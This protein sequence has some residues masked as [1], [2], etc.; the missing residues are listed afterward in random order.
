MNLDTNIMNTKSN[1]MN[2]ASSLSLK[3][4]KDGRPVALHSEIDR[5]LSLSVIFSC[6]L[7]FIRMIHTGRNTFLFL[8]WNLFLAW[9]PYLI[10][11]RLTRMQPFRPRILFAGLMLAWILLSRTL[12]ISSP[13][14]SMWAIIIM[15]A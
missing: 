13:I 2:L 3:P 9:L 6:L 1:S 15:T 10:T 12:F 8:L 7:V 4:Q 5:L 11:R 14:C